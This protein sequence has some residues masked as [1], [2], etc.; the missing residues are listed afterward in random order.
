[1]ST[2]TNYYT[3]EEAMKKLGKPRS[4]FFKE[5]ENGLIPFELDPGRQRG[6][7]YPKQAIDVLARRQ[8]YVISKK[9]HHT[10]SSHQ[11]ALP[12]SGQKCKSA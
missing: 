3:A 10:S 6:R 5:V 1:M 7:R 2:E 9:R 11:L 8:K 4:T 12:T